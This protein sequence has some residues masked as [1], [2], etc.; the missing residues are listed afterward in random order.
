MKI[1]LYGTP[2]EVDE[3]VE[4]LRD[5][6]VIHGAS[7]PYASRGAS[8]EAEVRVYVTAQ[9]RPGER[10]M[11]VAPP[12]EVVTTT[13]G[14]TVPAAQVRVTDR[15][16]TEQGWHRVVRVEPPAVDEETAA[17]FLYTEPD[18]QVSRWMFLPDAP[19]RRRRVLSAGGAR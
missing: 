6:F 5:V 11:V 8:R 16:W 2:A 18:A 13:A 1:R 7:R 14:E 15:V 17:V 9:L 4:A 19:V 12:A 3:A 10:T